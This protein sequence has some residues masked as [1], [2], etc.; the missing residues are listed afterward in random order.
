MAPRIGFA[1][2]GKH[3]AL[4]RARLDQRADTLADRLDAAI[5]RAEAAMQGYESGA[6]AAIERDIGDFEAAVT[7]GSNSLK[8]L[9]GA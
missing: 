3:H 8:N 7:E 6:M 5:T 2:L 9:S 1:G 4:A